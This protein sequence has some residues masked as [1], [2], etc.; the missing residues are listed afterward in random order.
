MRHLVLLLLLLAIYAPP[1][2]AQLPED[3]VDALVLTD[4]PTNLFDIPDITVDTLGGSG[5][6]PAELR[7]IPMEECGPHGYTPQIQ[8]K[9]YWIAFSAVTDG[10]LEFI[11]SPDGDGTDYDFA[12]FEGFC[13]NDQCSTP[14]FCNYLPYLC[15]GTAKTG[16]SDDPAGT[17]G[18]TE[19]SQEIH[20]A[21]INLKAG[22]N[23]YL[24]V[25]N[26]NESGLICPGENPDAGFTIDFDGSAIV[27]KLI[28]RPTISPQFPTDTSQIITACEG[29][30]LNF[31]VTKV[32]NASTY[33]WT[34]KSVA[35][36]TITPTSSDGDSVSVV[37][38]A[39]SG[40]IC[41]EMICPI[42]SLICWN[43]QV[44]RVPDLEAIPFPE[45]ACEPVNLNTRFRDNNNALGTVQFYGTAADAT[46]GTNPL[47]SQIVTNSGDYW[48]RVTTPNGCTD[49]VQMDVQV[50]FIDV[51][52]IDTFRFCPS[53]LGRNFVDLS[54]DILPIVS[55]NNAQSN[56]IYRFYEDS[57]SAVNNGPVITGGVI[58]ENQYPDNTFWVKIER[59][60][61][62]PGDCFGL[63]SFV[64][65]FDA[66]PEIAPIP[67]IALCSSECFQG[68]NMDL[69][70]PDGQPLNIPNLSFYADSLDA[71]TGTS[72]N[73]L[74]NS[75]IC[76]GGN[77][78]VRAE[79]SASCY[80]V[81]P[82]T[83]SFFPAPDV[84]DDTLAID[85]TVGCMDLTSFMWTDRNGLDPNIL[86][87][88]YFD[89]QAAA[90]D[91]AAPS[92]MDLVFCDPTEVWLRMTNT[93][94]GCFDVAKITITGV[95]LPTAALSLGETTICAGD[96]TNLE[97]NLTGDAPFI[98]SYSDGIDIFL[99]SVPSNVFQTAIHPDSTAIYSLISL[100][101]NNGCLGAA[102]GTVTLT[103][104][105]SPTI[106]AISENCTPDALEFQISFDVLGND[107]YTVTGLTGN[108]VGNNFESEFLPSG[109]T[110]SFQVSGTNGCPDAIQLPTVFSC[111]CNSIVGTM[112]L[113]PK[114]YCEREPAIADYLGSGFALEKDDLLI[115]VLHEGSDT[116]LVNPLIISND[117]VFVYDETV[118]QGGVTYYMSAVVTKL[119]NTGNPIVD[120]SRNPC[121][122]VAQGQPVT[123]YTVPEVNL[124]LSNPIICAGESMDLT[125]HIAG[126]GPYD[127]V[128]FDGTRQTALTEVDSGHTVTI[129]PTVDTEVYVE[130]IRQRGVANCENTLTPTD[131]QLAITVFEMPTIENISEQCNEIGSRLI[132]TFEVTGGDPTTYLVEGITGSFKGN[133]F[134]SDSLDQ[135][136]P[137]AISVTDANN[138][139]SEIASGVAECFCTPDIAV[140]IVT[141]KPV[142][143][144]GEQDGILMATPQNGME[145]YT[146]FWST[147]VTTETANNLAPS[148]THTVTMTDA[149]GCEVIDTLT[150][151]APTSVI[152]T[153]NVLDPTCY[154]ANDGTVLIIQTEGGTGDYTYSFD[155]GTFQSEGIRDNFKAGIYQVAVRDGN[156]CEWSSEVTLQD[157]PQFDV[158]LGGNANL[159]LGDSLTLKPMVNQDEGLATFVWESTDPTSCLDCPSQIIQPTTSG[160]YKVTAT[161]V[162][163]CVADASVLVQVQ[164]LRRLFIPSVFSPNG[165]G[166][167]DLLRPFSGSEVEDISMFRIFN[168]WGE[169]V[170][171]K[172]DMAD[173]EGWDGITKSG[174]KAPP[175]VYLYYTEVSWAN[176]TKDILTGDVSLVR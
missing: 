16:V 167:N 142:S 49:V 161:N 20:T 46:N 172:E 147:G 162:A 109:S 17:F 67:N 6:E 8:D 174:R 132:L 107:T 89:T 128:Y 65:I 120:A 27:D 24:L 152:A 95:P 135:G 160:R 80:D 150:L 158:S 19:M 108:L 106:G 97:I 101:D 173:S 64:I 71:E 32:P 149:N 60:G 91:P 110:Y 129:M 22:Y 139:P 124:S 52:I 5:N 131:N 63:T 119:D 157:P 12:L 92:R 159:N 1:L 114:E 62:N 154:N 137:Y 55:V 138:C 102:S 53:N 41:M 127:L 81:A 33:D 30:V 175:G 3:C 51:S 143:C 121:M 79:S 29:D 82:F 77:Y 141:V 54:A 40:Q 105:D 7:Q 130:S 9:S 146:Y 104:N 45:V 39:T 74:L 70:R 28:E 47:T 84:V 10:T 169:L 96:T 98:I 38:G 4:T 145:P 37:I 48:V 18:I 93:E 56:D 58:G 117:P 26:R 140:N 50:N 123:F 86:Q 88:D 163:G 14:I 103:V 78:W 100:M 42:Q 148:V 122:D 25:E 44:D 69:F 83:L 166:N 126:V 36:A 164:N 13:P 90:E 34:S 111:E 176:G 68:A 125:F 2:T 31:S 23:Y 11:I 151:A 136:T 72:S 59:Q 43:V 112:D 155:G 170:Y 66:A 165:D 35:D 171:E 21:A 61:Q 94:N 156:G 85:C 99:E 168:R 73:N 133:Q 113:L 15:S 144:A 115:F 116:L 118:L 57:A 134:I 87:A 153:T 76:V 75:E